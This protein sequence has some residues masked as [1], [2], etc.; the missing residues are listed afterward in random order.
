MF[1]HLLPL[2]NPN[3][4]GTIHPI[5]VNFPIPMALVGPLTP[6]TILR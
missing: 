5:L 6:P 4:P 3:L 2:H 1:D